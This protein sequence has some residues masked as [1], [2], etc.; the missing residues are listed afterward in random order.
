MIKRNEK[1]V[2]GTFGT[3][4]G[5]INIEGKRFWDGRFVK[6]FRFVAEQNPIES[7]S[8]KRKDLQSLAKGDLDKAKSHRD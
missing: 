5:F 6:P 2:A 8:S 1:P 4:L 7:D 3:Y